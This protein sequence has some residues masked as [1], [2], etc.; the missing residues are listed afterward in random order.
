[1]LA[2]AF[3]GDAPLVDLAPYDPDRFAP[4]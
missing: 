1:V 2:Q 4:Q 3:C